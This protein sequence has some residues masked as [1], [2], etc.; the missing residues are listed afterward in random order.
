MR[1]EP[2]LVL[3]CDDAVAAWVSARIPHMYGGEFGACVAIGVLDEDRGKVLAGFVLHDYQP[4]MG[5]IQLSMAAESPFWATKGTIRAILH[6]PFE[7]Y[8]CYKVWTATPHLNNMALKVNEHIGF[9]REATLAHHFG[10]AKHAVICRLLE[11][12]YR[13]I[14]YG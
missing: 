7:Q 6:I 3:G 10:K 1:K 2:K 5:T 9:K 11:P 8:G 12:D 13:K 14:F 4:Q